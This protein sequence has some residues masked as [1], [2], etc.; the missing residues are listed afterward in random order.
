MK[1]KMGNNIYSFDMH[2]CMHTH[3]ISKEKRTDTKW[4]E[5]VVNEIQVE[6]MNFLP[7]YLFV[8]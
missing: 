1:Y 6:D 3:V 8:L 4:N 7:L 5:N 2:A